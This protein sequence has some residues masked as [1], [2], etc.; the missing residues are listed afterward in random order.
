[1]AVSVDRQMHLAPDASLIDAVLPHLPFPLTQY[2][3]AGTVDDQV[4]RLVTGPVGDLNR[5][6]LLPTRERAVVRHRPGQPG[7][8]DQAP[9]H[10]LRSTQRQLKQHLEREHAL[11]G[12]VTE[13]QRPAPP[14]A[15]LRRM[16]GQI[17]R[18]P[19]GQ[20][21]ARDQ[22]LIVLAPIPRLVPGLGPPA[23]YR[24]LA[25]APLP[26]GF[27]QQSRFLTFWWPD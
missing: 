4:Q 24:F 21:T 15:A 20:V 14:P 10:A 7:Q 13:H 9:C 27:L 8:A 3:Q 5:Q 19:D 18:E 16:P 2:L 11:D 6:V 1:M 23:L 22:A 17:G 25:H 26:A 12:C